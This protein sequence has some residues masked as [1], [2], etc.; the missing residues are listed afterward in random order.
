MTSPRLSVLMPVYNTEP[1]YLSQAIDSI[2]SQSFTQFEFLI[3]DDGSTREDTLDTL[4]HYSHSDERIR[5]IHA[6]NGGLA[7]ARNRLLEAASCTLCAQMDSDDIARPERL[8][9]Q[10][11]LFENHPDLGICG[12]WFHRFPSDTIVSPPTVPG[13]LDYLRENCLG[14]PTIMYNKELLSRFA[15]TVDER[16]RICEDYDFNARTVRYLKVANVPEVLLDYRERPDSLAH[17]NLTALQEMDKLIQRSLLDHLTRN[18]SWRRAVKQLVDA[19]SHETKR[20][21]CEIPLAGSWRSFFRLPVVVRLMGG[22]GNQ[23]FQYAFGCALSESLGRKVKFDLSWFDEARKTIVDTASC[24]NEEGVVI[25]EY[26]LGFF[27]IKLPLA[28][29]FL[30][31]LCKRFGGIVVEPVGSFSKK[32]ESLLLRKRTGIWQGYFQNEG[33]FSHL[34]SYLEKA[35]SFPE[36]QKEDVFNQ[37]VLLDIR[38]SDNPVFVHIRKGDYVKLGWALEADY[39]GDAV[40]EMVARLDHPAF[41]VFGDYDEAIISAI[42]TRSSQVEWVGD[43]NAKR[44]EDWKDMALMMACHHAIIAN[45][46]FSWWAA[47]LGR[48]HRGIVMAPSPFVLETDEGI[49]DSWVKIPRK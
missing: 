32:E 37:R 27:P 16:I 24:E 47:W 48:A 1:E 38:L 25:R 2:L 40:A 28:G 35:F 42:R 46:S 10:L 26:A 30:R 36:F 11:A 23:M 44:S 17:A 33:Y 49:C 20:E 31:F 43:T 29:R 45:S 3:Y 6:K 15:L 41:F 13:M 19:N 12:T 5:V 39:Y 34:R 7:A 21:L 9:K 4:E 22:L 14:N 18:P 8:E